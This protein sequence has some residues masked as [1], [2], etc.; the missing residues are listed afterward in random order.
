MHPIV[1]Q[2]HQRHGHY[3]LVA[4]L[5]IFLTR[6]TSRDSAST[7]ETKYHMDAMN[8]RFFASLLKLVAYW[9]F[10]VF[11]AHNLGFQVN[12]LQ[13][14][15]GTSLSVVLGFATQSVLENVTS[16]LMLLYSRPFEV[17]DKIKAA[18]VTGKVVS[19]GFFQTRIMTSD[20]AGFVIPNKMITAG[21]VENFMLDFDE[22]GHQLRQ[23]ETHI[24]LNINA[25]LE[26]GIDA[27]ESAAAAM[28]TFVK[29][30]NADPQVKDFPLGKYSIAEHYKARYGR[31]LSD[32]QESHKASV[33]VSGQDISSGHSL[34]LN[35]MC[36]ST[37][38][39][40]V[41]ERSYREAVRALKAKNVQLF[42]P[43]N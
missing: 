12:E 38:G 31:V 32:D 10:G 5:A 41:K 40:K 1:K 34:I 30:L 26:D 19:V 20:N 33:K 9:C 42:D 27:L 37:L 36:E 22:S 6:A 15:I 3:A 2:I 29:D 25:N 13:T 35:I 21:T 4:V 14:S 8:V 24:A 16:A 43:S 23:Q 7:L 28:D 18:G 11:G 17:G 39:G